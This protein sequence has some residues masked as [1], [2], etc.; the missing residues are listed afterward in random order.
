MPARAAG[1]IAMTGACV[2]WGLSPLYWKLLAAVP[3]AEVLAHR[4]LW[5]LVTFLAI[6]A[7]RGRLGAL[8]SA[9]AS[10]REML[11]T[12]AAAALVSVN[13]FGFIYAVQIGRTMEASLGYYIFPLVAVLFGYL[14]DGDRLRPL[15]W[16][17]VAL[18]ATAVAVLT[19]GLGVVPRISL[20]LAVSFGLYGVLKR[21]LKTDPMASVTAEV[22]L[23]APIALA[24]LAAVHLAGWGAAP[25][26]EAAAFGADPGLSLLLAVSGVLTGLPLILFSYASQ[27]ITLPTLGLMTYLNPTLQ[28]FCATL[29]FGEPVTLWHA[30][31]FPMIW[32]GLALYSL[33]GWRAWRSASIAAAGS[34]TAVTVDSVA[35][36]ASSSETTWR[37][38]AS[39]GSQ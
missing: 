19:A 29:A 38:S 36:G 5:S 4:T 32:A 22:V 14:L 15:Q 10:R 16:L 9:F 12:A 39:K 31:A 13:W 18:A 8:R 26:R 6:L 28:F 21:R 23:L 25:G 27:R 35:S 30:I 7:L 37:S 3:A 34:V 2:I 24:W 33:D 11:L 17:A 20:M 1:L